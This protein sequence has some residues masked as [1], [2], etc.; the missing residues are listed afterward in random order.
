M[1]VDEGRVVRAAG[2]VT[3]GARVVAAVLA[4]RS[5]YAQDRSFLA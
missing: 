1:D 4:H 5:R 2:P 3:G